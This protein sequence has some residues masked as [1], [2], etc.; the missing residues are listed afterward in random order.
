MI[1]RTRGSGTT[2]LY[3]W[4]RIRVE[5]SPG[6]AATGN[7]TEVRHPLDPLTVEEFRKTTTILRRDRGL[8][9]RWRFASIELKEPSKDTVGSFSPGDP[10]SREALVV[11]WNR[12]DGQA[13]KAVVSLFD[14]RV[15]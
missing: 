9:A 5:Q 2:R 3:S 4:W 1:P 11:C 15:V 13:Y 8:D 14:D 7:S 6:Q 10:I 12:E